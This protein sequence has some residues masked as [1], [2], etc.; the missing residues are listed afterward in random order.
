MWFVCHLHVNSLY[1][2]VI[3]MAFVCHLSFVCSRMSFENTRTSLV[4]HSY[5]LVCHLYN[6]RMYSHVI[7]MYWYVTCMSLASTCMSSLVYT[8]MSFI[9]HLYVTRMYWYVTSKYSYVICMSLVCGFFMNQI[10]YRL[11]RKYF[12]LGS[13]ELIHVKS[14]TL[15]VCANI[16]QVQPAI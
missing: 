16:S 5:L 11:T 15:K 6:T 2:L 8:C 7:R 9:C 12:S 13:L 10:K 3:F 14:S 4:C 1:S